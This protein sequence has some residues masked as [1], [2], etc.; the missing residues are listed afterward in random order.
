MSHHTPLAASTRVSGVA[1]VL[2]RP[3]STIA[4]QNSVKPIR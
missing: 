2:R 3:S 1:L 4:S